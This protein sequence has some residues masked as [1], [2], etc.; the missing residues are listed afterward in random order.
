VW[1][2]ITRARRAQGCG[3]TDARAR[4]AM[5]PKYACCALVSGGKD[6]VLAAMTVD[7]RDD[8][9][10][11]C[12]ANLC[13]LDAT[14][15][16]LDSHCFQTV[17]HACVDALGECAGKPLFRRR[18]RGRSK[19]LALEYGSGEDGDEVEDLR[20]LLRAV[21]RAA[22]EVNSVCSGAILSDYQRLRVEA[23][24]AD[25]GLTSLAPLW[26]V[27]QR[28]VLRR[29]RDEGVDARLVKVAAMGLNP[30]THLGASIVDASEELC[31]IEDEYGSY[32]AGEGGEFETLVVDCP[33]FVRGRL[34]LTKTRAVKTSDDAFAP[35]GHLLV[36]AFEV[37]LKDNADSI[38]PGR[39]MWVEDECESVDARAA[40]DAS[41]STSDGAFSALD[42]ERVGVEGV[43]CVLRPT[44][45]ASSILMCVSVSAEGAASH[46]ACADAIFR[47]ARARVVERLGAA[48][49]ALAWPRVAMTHV[50]LDDMSQFARV[51]AV[52]SKHMPAVAPSARACVATRFHDDVKVQIDCVFV[53]DARAERKS[54]HVQ[55]LSSWAPACIGPYGQCVRASGLAYVAGQ[56]GMEPTTLDLVPGVDAQLERATRSAAAV[57]DVVGA[58]LGAR[59]LAVTLYTNAAH[60]DA[61]AR[62]DIDAHPSRV[63]LR[64][65]RR[66]CARGD[67][68]FSW[69]PLVTQLVVADLPKNAVGEIVPTLL[70]DDGPSGERGYVDDDD[71][72]VGESRA[73]EPL[74]DDHGVRSR[75]VLRASRFA[76]CVVSAPRSDRPIDVIIAAASRHVAARLREAHLRLDDDDDIALAVRLYHASSA[77]EDAVALR[78][79]LASRLRLDLNAPAL[80]VVAVPVL[81]CGI[82]DD[83]DAAFV[84]DAHACRPERARD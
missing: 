48:A 4:V 66:E 63:M 29:V 81:A 1:R 58:P 70:V 15:E 47:Y 72:L 40:S 27:P 67:R 78:R 56:I 71:S 46:E 28:E 14:T 80:D 74:P 17:A 9:E 36:D 39:V 31:R 69:S 30:A 7:A 12:F 25:L 43:E 54:L 41:P 55:S 79:A 3:S 13:P 60:D 22:P 8:A 24:C 82:D 44:L 57:A 19:R 76:R 45:T 10:V 77:R 20:A 65:L 37:V 6:G 59:A 75:S 26:R 84:L 53:L 68:L 49:A 64:A 73:G 50:Y 38:E 5:P 33:M 42:D 34:A 51:N 52:Y 83:L 32:C 35:S 11:V 23:V 21:T 2:R 16:E 18:I 62:S 61:H